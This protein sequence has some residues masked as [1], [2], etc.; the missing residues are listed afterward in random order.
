MASC[1]RSRSP[2]RC[3]TLTAA[4]LSELQ[5]LPQRDRQRLA[6]LRRLV[7]RSNNLAAMQNYG[8]VALQLIR[9]LALVG[10][11]DLDQTIHNLTAECHPIIQATLTLNEQI[12]IQGQ[13]TLT[14]IEAVIEQ[15]LQ[16]PDGA[17]LIQFVTHF[18]CT[19]SALY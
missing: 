16:Q 10:S 4:I 1:D 8:S 12:D 13:Q 2:S 17:S 19:A 3:R 11:T 14:E 7:F 9:S 5:A 15:L 6:G 18:R